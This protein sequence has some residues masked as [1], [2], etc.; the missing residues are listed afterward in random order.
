MSTDFTAREVRAFDLLTVIVMLEQCEPDLT[1]VQYMVPYVD[2]ATGAICASPTTTCCL[3]CLYRRTRLGRSDARSSIMMQVKA[4][5]L[6]I[7][8]IRPRIELDACKTCPPLQR[9]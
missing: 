2:R 8:D 5:A 9:F 7:L 6:Q 3:A 1:M 4:G